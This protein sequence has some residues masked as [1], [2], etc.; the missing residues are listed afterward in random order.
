VSE[1]T[2]DSLRSL[3]APTNASKNSLLEH[4]ELD[5]LGFPM[6]WVHA[7]KAYVHWMPMTRI[8]FELFLA[9]GGAE[10]LNADW[11]A[12]R[13]ESDRR[14]SAADLTSENFAQCLLTGVLPEEAQIIADWLGPDFQLLTHDEWVT[15]LRAADQEE[16]EPVDWAALPA[17]SMASPRCIEL[18]RALGTLPL[19]GPWGL[20]APEAPDGYHPPKRADQMLLRGGVLEWVHTGRPEAPWGGLGQVHHTLHRR[21]PDLFDED[22]VIPRQPTEERIGYFGFRLARK[23][24]NPPSPMTLPQLSEENA[25]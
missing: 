19:Q 7:L 3:Q 13:C 4:L 23:A 2:K 17:M 25:S 16:A 10:E 21:I 20:P 6:V 18:L 14:P 8:Q 22:V 5:P 24:S 12:K 11:Y 1:R 9:R 15:V